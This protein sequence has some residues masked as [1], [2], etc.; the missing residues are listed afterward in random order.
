MHNN[1]YFLPPIADRCP[2]RFLPAIQTQQKEK[3]PEEDTFL[4]VDESYLSF[5]P[6]K[7]NCILASASTDQYHEVSAVCM[8]IQAGAGPGRRKYLKFCTL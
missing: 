4:A 1:S 8:R 6:W 5:T 2:L 7:E 3:K